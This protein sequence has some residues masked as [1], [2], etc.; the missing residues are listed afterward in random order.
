VAEGVDRAGQGDGGRAGLGHALQPRRAQG[1]GVEASRRAARAVQA[2]DAVLARHLHQ[3]ESVA[4]EAAHV[5][6]AAAEQEGRG[7]RGI[8]GVAAAEERVDGDPRGERVGGGGHAVRRVDERPAGL[9]EVAHGGVPLVSAGSQARGRGRC[10]RVR[11]GP[12]R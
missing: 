8:D 2:A 6:L 3:R 9:L 1:L 12:P 7:E 10:K 5:R 4:A 11:P